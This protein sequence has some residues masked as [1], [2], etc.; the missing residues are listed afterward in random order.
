LN[1]DPGNP[2]GCLMVQGAL[3]SGEAAESVREELTA[4]RAA[5]EAALRRRLQYAKSNGDLS[6][7]ADP[8]RLARYIATVIYGIAVQAAGG[9]SREQLQPVIEITLRTLPL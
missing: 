7:D 2:G 8:A 5:G 6:K 1:T 3:A 4:C 9:A